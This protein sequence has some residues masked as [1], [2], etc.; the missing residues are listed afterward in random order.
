[1][2]TATR[3]TTTLFFAAAAVGLVA[4]MAMPTLADGGGW[5]YEQYQAEEAARSQLAA[6]AAQTDRQKATAGATEYDGPRFDYWAER[7]GAQRFN[8]D[9]PVEEEDHYRGL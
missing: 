5:R 3:R 2:T 9:V 7:N 4:G 8:I 1:M 6:E